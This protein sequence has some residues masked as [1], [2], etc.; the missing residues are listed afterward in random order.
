[1]DNLTKDDLVGV[2]IA[3]MSDNELYNRYEDLIN[4]YD[5]YHLLL[6][7]GNIS[8]PV[9]KDDAFMFMLSEFEY[10]L[11]KKKYEYDQDINCRNS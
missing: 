1:M 7:Q 5:E 3:G 2:I 6:E 9:N 8:F 4:N 11:G 10:R